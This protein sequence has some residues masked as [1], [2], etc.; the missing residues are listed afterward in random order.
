MAGLITVKIELAGAAQY[1]ATSPVVT[2][3]EVININA[4][5]PSVTARIIGY[6]YNVAGTANDA[7][8]VLTPPGSASGTDEDIILENRLTSA[9]EAVNNFTSPCGPGGVVV[10]R[11]YGIE[12]TSQPPALPGDGIASAETYQVFFSTALKDGDGTFYL[13]Y[14][15]DGLEGDG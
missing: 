10:P 6:A 11:R 14:A 7:R 2:F 12:A 1:V 9:S 4:Q 13:W 5:P 15:I 3:Q 8:L